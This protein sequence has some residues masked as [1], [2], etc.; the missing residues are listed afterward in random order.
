MLPI[1]AAELKQAFGRGARDTQREQPPSI[2]LLSFEQELIS[3]DWCV[4]QI[5]GASGMPRKKARRA[6]PPGF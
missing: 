3:L 5:A 6:E 1:F 2:A 4:V